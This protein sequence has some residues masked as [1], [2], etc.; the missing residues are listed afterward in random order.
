M[1]TSSVV[2]ALLMALASTDALAGA[3]PLPEPGVLE[4]L[5]IGGIAALVI[6]IRKR[7][8]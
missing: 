1:R 8:K 3:R 2:A 4:L 7:R 5:S 6:A